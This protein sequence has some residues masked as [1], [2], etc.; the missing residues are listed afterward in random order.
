MIVYNKL[1]SVLKNREISFYALREVY[2]IDKNT[3]KRL[4]NNQNVTVKTLDKLC[5][6]LNCRLDEIAEYI[7]DAED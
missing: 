4:K 3:L 6:I 7:P 1:W 5:A 2:G